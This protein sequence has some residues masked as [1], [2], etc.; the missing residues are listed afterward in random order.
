MGRRPITEDN[1]DP[2]KHKMPRNA[3][4]EMKKI[5]GKELVDSISQLSEYTEIY[6]FDPEDF[7]LSDSVSKLKHAKM[8]ISQAATYARVTYGEIFYLAIEAF[9]KDLN[10]V[11]YEEFDELKTQYPEYTPEE[12]LHSW[13]DSHEKHIWVHHHKISKNLYYL[14]E[15]LASQRFHFP[16]DTARLIEKFVNENVIPYARLSQKFGF[17]DHFKLEE[18][19]T[20][21]AHRRFRND[22][23]SIRSYIQ[24][25]S[26][27]IEKPLV[28]SN[29][30]VVN[31]DSQ[32]LSE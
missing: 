21:L 30:A 18:V 1:Y 17:T 16:D 20:E 23:V 8:V 27:E 12:S 6:Q 9:A 24:A 31:G 7:T 11:T 4:E 3:N 28:A 2:R 13:E 22:S 32:V 14:S 25:I 10:E 19:I 15:S 26:E 29:E 5:T